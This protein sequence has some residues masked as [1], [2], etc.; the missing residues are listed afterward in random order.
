M[1]KSLALILS[2]GLLLSLAACSGSPAAPDCSTAT[3]PG[4]SSEAITA[5][6]KLGADPAASFP[7]PLVAQNA[8]RS[9]LI[10]GSG[11]LVG[12]GSTV[13]VDYSVYDGETGAAAGAPQSTALVLAD[14]LPE[15]LRNGLLCTSA[16]ER[17][18]IV[19]PND[20]ATTIF[21]GA[22]GSVVMVFDI[23]STFPRTATG[24]D[25]PAQAGFPSVVHDSTG[26]PGITIVSGDTPTE[27]KSAL[28]KKG[29]GPVVAE[30]DSIIVQSLAV[31]YATPDKVASSTWED[32][33]PLLWEMT[34][35]PA[36]GS[37]STTPAGITPFLVGQTVG[38]EVLVVLP[39]AA[40]GTA[41]AYVVDI[42][43][44]LPTAS[45][46]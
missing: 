16:G 17:V 23:T 41:T 6:G 12:P 43:G 11:E 18:A 19:L 40:G 39:D 9:V 44:V 37:T 13:V 33:S 2:A 35:T 25:Q 36:A 34:E 15:G 1:R 31:S 14:S 26:R 10:P 4:D 30:G 45:G 5:T 7:F 29:G 20:Q 8:E 42:L 38:S 24:A 22:T 3:P 46:N 21:S 28:L 27:A 32:G